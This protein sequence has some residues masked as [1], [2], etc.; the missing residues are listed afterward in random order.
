M[1]KK[2]LLIC[3]LLC[4]VL[5]PGQNNA[6]FHL[7]SLPPVDTITYRQI[8]AIQLTKPW[9]YQ[10]GDDITWADSSYDD[11]NWQLI[12]PSLDLE[13]LPENTFENI[14]WFRL[15]IEVDSQFIN[16]TLG[17]MLTQS[18]ASEIYLDGK[19]LH[20]FGKINRINPAKEER[21]DPLKLPVDIR[22]EKT[23]KHL[24]AVRYADAAAV[25]DF[26]KRGISSAGFDIFIGRLRE[27]IAFRYNGS[28][29][30]AVI[31]IFYFTFFIALCFMHLMFF[32]FY[33]TN[34]SNLY[35]SIFAAG[36]GLYFFWIF[37]RADFVYPDTINKMNYFF[38]HLYDIYMTAL[39][40]MLYTIF[41]KKL[42]K[43][44]W[45]WSV[46]AAADFILGALN[47]NIPYFGGLLFLILSIEVIRII[48]VSI[49]RKLDGSR[50]I[51]F[52]VIIMI[53]FFMLFTVLG[54]IGKSI[55]FNISGW[56]GLIIGILAIY[57]TSSVPI[58]MS[59]YL[60]REF[61]RTSRNLAKKLVEVEDLSAKAI[62]QEKEK[63]KIL[64]N[65]KETL[66][67]QVEERTSEI[68]KQ[69][70]II[71]E[72]NKDITDS[73][74]YAKTIQN[75]ILPSKELKQELFP[76]SFVLFKPKDIV[77]GDFYWF[78]EKD[79]KKLIATCD[80]TGHGVPGALMS[81]I[82]NNILNQIV[83]EKGHTSPDEILNQL[84]KEIR[85]SLK[86]EE[87]NDTKDG[88]DIALVT[89][90]TD[91]EIEFA[92]AQRPLWIIRNTED[93]SLTEIK[94]DKYAIGGLQAEAERK[95]TNH[96]ITLSKGDRIYVSTDGF[97]DQ[98]NV[99][100]KKL[101]TSK[102]KEILLSIRQKSMPEQE[103]FLDDYIEDWK[104]RREQIDDILVIGIK[105]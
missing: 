37:M 65:Q 44:F 51:G 19:L 70:T 12:D 4:A 79:G 57:A 34:K 59:I 28:I 31:F 58:S 101:M 21:Y 104:G 73:I 72:K 38:N 83:N 68:I 74:N 64:E 15:H 8:P 92:G 95:F 78:A 14:G 54:F 102:F 85:K 46:L 97:A 67:I 86:Q 87:Q 50:I 42:P 62:D 77:S 22:F 5:M 7:D 99:S 16:Q 75:A 9:K 55:N 40:A 33:R 60:A 66:E 105:I 39:L 41:N 98:F 69:K 89:F 49:Y 43:L 2:L 48:I 35:Y 47:I 26:K 91:S 10:K 103:K 32:I 84:H 80:C 88:M 20:K 81:M 96:K 1:K 24:L 36:V 71:E 25:S 13:K 3:F 17:L 27:N 6:V 53:L 18:G 63:Q 61:S 90:N 30:P 52:G 82:G 94:G 100:D 45:I 93:A 23:R 76:E 29:F 56:S 11:S